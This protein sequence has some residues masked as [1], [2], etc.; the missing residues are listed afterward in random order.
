MKKCGSD[1]EVCAWYHDGDIVIL[2]LSADNTLVATS[3]P[4]SCQAVSGALATH[5]Q[6]TLN[7]DPAEFNHLN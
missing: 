4:K 5:F 3:N 7:T 6:L 1:C 2:N